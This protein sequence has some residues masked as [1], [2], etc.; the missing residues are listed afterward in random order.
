MS[1]FGY[2]AARLHC[3]E[4]PLDA[5]AAGAC[6][7]CGRPPPAGRVTPG[8]RAP[9]GLTGIPRETAGGQACH[10]APAEVHFV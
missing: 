3:E 5:V 8:P 2:R 9:T 4:T 6:T 1:P 7:G 10:D